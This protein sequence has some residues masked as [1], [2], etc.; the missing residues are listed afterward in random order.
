MDSV[1]SG[2]QKPYN[3]V[4]IRFKAYVERKSM[5]REVLLIFEHASKQFDLARYF[6]DV[7]LDP[8]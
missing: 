5:W 8:F 2:P 3:K 7:H 6:H 1:A 4:I